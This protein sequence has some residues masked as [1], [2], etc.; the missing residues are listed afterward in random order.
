MADDTK[1]SVG[2]HDGRQLTRIQLYIQEHF[3]S[4][5]ISLRSSYIGIAL[6]SRG[7]IGRILSKDHSIKTMVTLYAFESKIP[8]ILFLL[9]TN[10]PF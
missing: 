9:R 5:K 6:F 1:T 8:E 10:M 4:N 3:R 2:Q 7:N